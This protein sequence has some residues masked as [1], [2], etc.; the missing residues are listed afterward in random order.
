MA[1]HRSY[2]VAFKRQVAQEL[3]G[4]ESLNGLVRCHDVS[5]NLAGVSVAKYEAC[6]FDDELQAAGLLQQ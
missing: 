2:S 1:R 3:L 5:R 6:A 4:G